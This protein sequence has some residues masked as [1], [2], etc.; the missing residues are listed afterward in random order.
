M[1]IDIAIDDSVVS[2]KEPTSVSVN[3][4]SSTI[5]SLTSNSI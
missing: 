2:C 4:E 3:E 1:Y 5:S